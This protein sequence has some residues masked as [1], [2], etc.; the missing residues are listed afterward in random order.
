MTGDADDMRARLRLTLPAHWFAD[1]APVL[2]GILYGLSSAWVALFALLQFIKTQCRIG[3][4][5]NGFLD[6]AAQDYLGAAVS[7]RTQ[8]TDDA[9]RAR[10]LLAM[11]RGRATRQAIVD[12]AAAA[13]FTVQIFEAA[14][15]ADTGA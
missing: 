3:T 2:D 9:F 12:A 13:G 6:M 8:E 10:L 4:A 5:T 14:R 15:P 1:T 7:R 11:Q